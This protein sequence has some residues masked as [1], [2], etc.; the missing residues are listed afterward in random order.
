M[1][2]LIKQICI[3]IDSLLRVLRYSR[4]TDNFLKLAVIEDTCFVLGNGPSLNMDLEKCKN[5]HCLGNAWCVN[6]FANTVLYESIQPK[7]YVFADPAYWMDGVSEK[8]NVSRE[9]LFQNIQNKTTWQLVIYAPYD[10]KGFFEKKFPHASKFTLFFYN[11]VPV[12][13]AKNIINWLYDKGLGMPFVQNVLVA[14]LFLVLRRG[15]KKIVILGADHSWH[16]TL[17]LDDNN[18]V[19]LRDKHFYETDAK[20]VPFT[21][22]LQQQTTFTMPQIFFALARMFEGYWCAKEFSEYV[23]AEIYNASSVTYIDAFKRID[24]SIFFNHHSN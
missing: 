3:T 18:R 2:V 8:L 20:L 4:I 19:C 23:G 14:A 16:E 24:S 21:N 5:L 15:H 7:N 6:D 13:G 22:D 10:A 11:N 12:I 9:Q 17:A 1:K